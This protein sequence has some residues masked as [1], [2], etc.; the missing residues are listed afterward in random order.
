[1]ILCSRCLGWGVPSSEPRRVSVLLVFLVGCSESVVLYC[2]VTHSPQRAH[3]PLLQQ[4]SVKPL[5][6]NGRSTLLLLLHVSYRGVLN[7]YILHRLFM[8]MCQPKLY[9]PPPV[10]S[11]YNQTAKVQLWKV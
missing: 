1:M 5:T 8:I 4:G 11:T 7:T 3:P 10:L 2:E 6:F 9:L